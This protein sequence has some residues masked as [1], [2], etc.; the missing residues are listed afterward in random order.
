MGEMLAINIGLTHLDMSHCR[1]GAAACLLIA[2]GL[3]VRQ[4]ARPGR[5]M[6][7]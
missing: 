5:G 7:M 2:E 3:K 4:L 1:L 6:R